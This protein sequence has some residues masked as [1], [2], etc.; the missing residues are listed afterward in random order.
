MYYKDG[1]RF[2]LFIKP[3]DR[4]KRM[5]PSGPNHGICFGSREPGGTADPPQGSSLALERNRG[6]HEVV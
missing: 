3:C 2:M 6:A 1:V 4:R 5:A